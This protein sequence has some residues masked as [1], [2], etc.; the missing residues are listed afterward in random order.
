MI[1]KVD[2]NVI[3]WATK[4]EYTSLRRI[5]NRYLAVHHL[6]QVILQSVYP[7]WSG[8]NES[9]SWTSEWYNSKFTTQL[10]VVVAYVL[11]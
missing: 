10:K 1:N 3:I 11:W 9:G 4:K 7:L 2:E 6:K 8:R 5:K